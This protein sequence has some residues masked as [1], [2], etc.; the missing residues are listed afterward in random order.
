[1]TLSIMSRNT[2]AY[3]CIK[4]IGLLLIYLVIWQAASMLVGSSLLF[5][6][7]HET[8]KSLLRLLCDPLCWR[9]IV[10]TFLRLLTGFLIGGTAGILLAVLTAKYPLFRWLLSPLRL[11]IKATPV[12]SFVLIL[13]VSIVSDLVPVVVSAI[14]V[15]PL[16]WATTEQA[17]LSLDPKLSEMGHVY[18]SPSR[19]LIH[20]ALPQMM[21]QITASGVTALGFAWK[22]VITAEVLSLP[23]FAIGNR[24]YLSKLYLETADTL[25]WTILIVSLALAM[26]LL[27]RFITKKGRHDP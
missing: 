13:L 22:A 8:A 2:I 9:D 7:P 3:K 20:I 15:A 16:L 18:F 23:K 4:T 24:M 19:R 14:M 11:L 25:A 1:M 10:Y 12:M 26:E 5:P 17:I 27:L 6:S 21:P